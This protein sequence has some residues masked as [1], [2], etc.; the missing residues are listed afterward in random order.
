YLIHAGSV[1]VSQCLQVSK[2]WNA[3][4]SVELGHWPLFEEDP[5]GKQG[6]SIDR[7]RCS[8][9]TPLGGE[10]TLFFHWTDLRRGIYEKSLDHAEEG[11]GRIDAGGTV[12]CCLLY[13]K[14][15]YTGMM[16]GRIKLWK[17]K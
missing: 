8:T 6:I 11:R 5:N 15:L 7:R 2:S 9:K 12:T 13:S 1:A 14:V 10:Q 16:D 4:I 17:L 3:I